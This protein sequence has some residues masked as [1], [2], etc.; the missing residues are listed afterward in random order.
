MTARLAAAVLVAALAVPT[1]AQ[2]DETTPIPDPIEMGTTVSQTY[3]G[4]APEPMP[5]TITITNLDAPEP[6]HPN[7]L[8]GVVTYR[9][10]LRRAVS[11][12][13]QVYLARSGVRVGPRVAAT[14]RLVTR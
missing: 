9:H 8:A 5:Y 1:A 13:G 2:A 14:F 7:V 6:W 12:D 3:F 10:H 11:V 4:P